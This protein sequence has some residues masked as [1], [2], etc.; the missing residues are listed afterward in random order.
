[1][2]KLMAAKTYLLL[3]TAAG[4]GRLYPARLPASLLLGSGLSAPRLPA[5]A[6]A[7]LLRLPQR[8]HAARRLAVAICSSSGEG[9]QTDSERGQEGLVDSVGHGAACSGRASPGLR[10]A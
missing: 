5:L 9:R 10:L 4:P 6:L 2:L 3:Y 7:R 8:W 1:M